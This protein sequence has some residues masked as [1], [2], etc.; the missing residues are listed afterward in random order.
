MDAPS[1]TFT[2]RWLGGRFF[3]SSSILALSALAPAEAWDSVALESSCLS[4]P[5]RLLK[6]LTDLSRLLPPF[7]V[8]FWESE[9]GEVSD[10]VAAVVSSAL[11]VSAVSA[12]FVCSALSR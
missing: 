6:G 4:S 5:L 3:S 12:V 8:S 9:V 10:V 7:L 2:P 1:G 11:V